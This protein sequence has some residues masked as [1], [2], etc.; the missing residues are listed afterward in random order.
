MT[1]QVLAQTVEEDALAGRGV[2]ATVRRRVL[3]WLPLGVLA[4]LIV[5]AVF[6]Q[7]FGTADP[8]AC[9]ISASA[10]PSS[11]GHPF[12]QDLQ[13]CDV[14]ANVVHGARASLSVGLFCTLIALV[15]AVLIGTIAGYVGGWTD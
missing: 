3:F 2:W 9:D 13:G 4:V 12:G 5:M 6:P 14:Y 1:D 10:R 15:I 8:R 11:P 7:L